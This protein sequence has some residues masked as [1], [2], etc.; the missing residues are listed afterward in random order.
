MNT[1]DHVLY[2]ETSSV[3]VR[4]PR[5]TS[6]PQWSNRKPVAA[7]ERRAWT[8]IWSLFTMSTETSHLEKLR[9][10]QRYMLIKENKFSQ[11]LKKKK[12]I[13]NSAL[14][15][16]PGVRR[17]L[18]PSLRSVQYSPHTEECGL[19]HWSERLHARQENWTGDWP[20][21]DLRVTFNTS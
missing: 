21:S 8:E 4:R 5:F 10:E 16:P 20:W 7:V 6:T 12:K 19:C 14:S 17:I 11:I 1:F 13:L 15:L 2:L 9:F 18:C 3:T